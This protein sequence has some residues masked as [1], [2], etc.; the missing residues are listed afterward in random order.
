MQP[1]KSSQQHIAWWDNN[2]RLYYLSRFLE[3]FEKYQYAKPTISTTPAIA[4]F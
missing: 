3:G 4:A 1:H 2:P